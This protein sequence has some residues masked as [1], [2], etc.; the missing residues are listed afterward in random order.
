MSTP[1]YD[2]H[3]QLL[4]REEQA[5]PAW[6]AKIPLSGVQFSENIVSMNDREH[7]RA[8]A[9]KKKF[10]RTLGMV[11]ARGG[12]RPQLGSGRVV[13]Y[14][15][16]PKPGRGVRTVKEVANLQPI[17]KALIDGLVDAGMFKDDSD[18]FVWGQDARRLPFDGKVEVIIVVWR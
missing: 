7:F 2:V 11:A 1:T 4:R 3:E 14:F 5:R 10:W 13:V 16:L 15:R 8:S 6:V 18:E 17:V 9:P 12:G